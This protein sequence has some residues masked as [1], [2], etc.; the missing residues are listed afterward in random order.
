MV[1]TVDSIIY[2]YSG[3]LIVRN[4][5]RETRELKCDNDINDDKVL[6][7][8]CSTAQITPKMLYDKEPYL[9]F[10]YRLFDCDWIEDYDRLVEQVRNSYRNKKKVFL[11]ST[12]DELVNTL[13]NLLE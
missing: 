11:P 8:F 3:D 9:V 1:R 4:H 2:N 13:N 7:A 12:L 10:L 5:P 6:I